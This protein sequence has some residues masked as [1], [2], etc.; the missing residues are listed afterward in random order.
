MV[1]A[2]SIYIYYCVYLGRYHSLL[3]PTNWCVTI[4]GVSPHSWLRFTPILRQLVSELRLS[5]PAAASTYWWLPPS[6]SSSSRSLPSRAEDSPF[7]LLLELLRFFFSWAS[8]PGA[9]RL[10][11]CCPCCCWS[12]PR[13]GRHL[14]GAAQP[15]GDL[16][17]LGDTSLELG[18][19]QEQPGLLLELLYRCCPTCCCCWSSLIFCSSCPKQADLLQQLPNLT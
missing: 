10:F 6:R 9:K 2:L 16:L 19:H 8:S 14:F 15:A 12:L 11:H 5:L 3:I 18:D 17:E 4:A 1:L 7:R 13:A